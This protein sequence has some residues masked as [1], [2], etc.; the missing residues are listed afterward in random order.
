MKLKPIIQARAKERQTLG[1]KSDEGGRT[2]AELGKI[3][4]VGKD[5][6]AGR[7]KTL[8]VTGCRLRIWQAMSNMTNRH[9]ETDTGSHG[10]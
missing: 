2:D 8:T 7:G 6:I 1:L 3:A 5:T 9:T 4:N 10:L